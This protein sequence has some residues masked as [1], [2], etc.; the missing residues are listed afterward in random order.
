MIEY[1]Q[2]RA[3]RAFKAGVC[4]ELRPRLCILVGFLK[5]VAE[6]LSRVLMTPS[7]IEGI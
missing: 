7:S 5:V 2:D 4:Y 1:R 3:R 6:Y